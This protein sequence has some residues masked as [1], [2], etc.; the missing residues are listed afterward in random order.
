VVTAARD[1][2]QHY[3]TLLRYVS[4]YR[5][6]LV[7]INALTLASTG[8]A[9]L[10]PL[11]LMVLID[12]VIGTE[13]P[14]GFLARLPGADS[15]SELLVWVV[16]AGLVIF[17]LTSAA[18]AV[19]SWL[20]IR[21][22]Q[23]MV[24]D[25]TR[26]AY[27]ATLRRSWAFHSRHEIGDSLSRITGDSWGV[28][29]VAESFVI[30]P[31]QATLAIVALL[32]IMF[33]ISVPLTLLAIVVVPFMIAGSIVLGS[34]IRG[35]AHARRAAEGNLQSLVQQTLSGVSI[36]QAFT[37]EDRQRHE[38]RELAGESIR[39]QQRGVLYGAF[40]SLGSG[41][42]VAVGTALVT[43]YGAHQV[44]DH[45]LTTGEL[46]AYLAYL[47][48]LQDQLKIVAGLYRTLQESG[49]NVDRIMEVLG[50]DPEVVDR[51]GASAL[52]RVR[53]E[54]VL[55]GV[56]FGYVPGVPVLHDVDLRVAAGE[57]VAIVGATGAGK[58]TLVSLVPRFFDP[59]AG[60]V[61]VDGHDVRDHQLLSVRRQVSVV[62]QDSFLFP[63][64]VA[65]NIAYGRP[66]A[67][68]EEIEAAARVANADEFIRALPEGYD[69]LIGERGAT[70]SGG[71]RQRVA[72]ARAVLKDAPILILDEPTSALDAR[73]EH[74]LL[75]ALD[76]L[77]EGRTTLVI[78]HRLSTIR[79]ADRIVTLDHGHIT[80]VE[81]THTTGAQPASRP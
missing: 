10:A 6:G 60:R 7:G 43:W 31:V 18:D 17:A 3:R 49:A 29:A 44:L 32:W 62:L 63:M 30:H 34:R 8:L 66:D 39:W 22:G 77:M 20:W 54:V 74:E 81:Q 79:N 25:V 2:R 23:A 26:D 67:A 36:V 5:I 64:S 40:N 58:S 68:R 59:S 45:H 47:L 28:H 46:L 21:V 80:Q 1:T 71:E 9:L 19:L 11:P 50:A 35:A 55:E 65:D 57:T 38:F 33:A 78:A 61:L 69:T 52:P 4:R 76:R 48:M 72:I 53:G 37:Q 15:R 70:F 73:T 51:P 27:R 24:F 56:S 16:L 14:T 13:Q 42:A 75:Q 41:I 12:N